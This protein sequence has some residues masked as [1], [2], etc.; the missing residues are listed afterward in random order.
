MVRIIA[1][2]LG[3]AAVRVSVDDVL[4]RRGLLQRD[5]IAFVADR[6]RFNIHP[7]VSPG[8]PAQPILQFQSG[9]MASEHGTVAINVLGVFPDGDSVTA[10]DTD[11]ADIVLTDFIA[12]LDSQFG[13]RF[14]ELNPPHLYASALVVEFQ[15]S[16][17][18]RADTINAIQ[19]VV[20][21]TLDPSHQSYRLKRLGFG[22]DS[23]NETGPALSVSHILPPDVTIERRANEPMDRNRFFCV[24]PLTTQEHEGFLRRIE[25]AVTG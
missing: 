14:S 13:Y 24:A 15:E 9:E 3:T 22:C 23:S 4:P 2:V 10:Q 6:Y 20:N 7:S 21:Q 17:V 18:R 19:S 12:Q 8:A 5:L 16:F 1:S 25:Q 11:L